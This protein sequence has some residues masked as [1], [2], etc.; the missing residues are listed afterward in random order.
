MH[1]MIDH[2]CSI[3]EYDIVNKA[4]ELLKIEKEQITN[5][6]YDGGNDVCPNGKAGNIASE[7]Y[8]SDTFVTNGG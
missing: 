8:Y 5:A 6:Y 2:L 1:E 4:N 3:G 7:K